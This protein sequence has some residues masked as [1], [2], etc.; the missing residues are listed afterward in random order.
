[1]PTERVYEGPR[2]LMCEVDFMASLPPCVT[3]LRGV[4]EHD[5]VKVGGKVFHRACF[6]CQVRTRPAAPSPFPHYPNH[7][8][9][10]SL[11][12]AIRRHATSRRSATCTRTAAWCS[13]RPASSRV[14]T[15]FV[16]SAA[17]PS[18]PSLYSLR[19]RSATCNASTARTAAGPFRRQMPRL[20]ATS[21]TA[22]IAAQSCT[23]DLY[24]THFSA[25]CL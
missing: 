19:T 15:L 14:R 11:S 21:C 6:K 7:T 24:S 22:W 4:P 2:G 12:C 20:P 18:R 10:A 17:S 3:C 5:Q 8:F 9:L 25:A 13:A 23:V 16:W 1:L